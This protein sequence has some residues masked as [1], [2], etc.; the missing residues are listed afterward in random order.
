MNELSEFEQRLVDNLPLN[1]DEVLLLVKEGTG[2][3]IKDWDSITTIEN[4]SVNVSS[5]TTTKSGLVIN[6]VMQNEQQAQQDVDAYF[7]CRGKILAIG[8]DAFTHKARFPNEEAPCKVGEWQLFRPGQAQVFKMKDG[9]I[10]AYLTDIY[11]GKG[12]SEEYKDKFRA[13]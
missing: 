9:A 11:C 5:L 6:A 1:S 10:I 13:G 4:E 3:E 2:K 8:R 12:L 7:V